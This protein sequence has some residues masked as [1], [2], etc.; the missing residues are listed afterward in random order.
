MDADDWLKTIEKKLQVV[1]CTNRERVLFVEHQLVRL[2][3]DWW[4]TYVEAHEEPETINWQ[5]FRNN[6]RT[7]HMPLGMMKL[8][9]KEFEDLKQGSVTVSEYV[10]HSTQFSRYAPDDMDMYENKQDWFLNELNDG[11]AYALEARNF[12]NFQDMVNKA[13]VLENRRGIMERKR[14]M[15]RIEAKGSNKRFHEGSSSQ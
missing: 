5:E 1:Q 10:T 14:K 2:A 15:H 11:L 6:F 13:L 3:A 9:K 4:D 8:K 7:H 12:E